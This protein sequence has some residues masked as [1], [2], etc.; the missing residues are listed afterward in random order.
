MRKN[1]NLVKSVVLIRL[2]K[3]S[4][5]IYIIYITEVLCKVTKIQCN[6]I[7]LFQ[8]YYAVIWHSMSCTVNGHCSVCIKE[9]WLDLGRFSILYMVLLLRGP[10]HS[11]FLRSGRTSIACTKPLESRSTAVPVSTSIDRTYN[12]NT[13]ANQFKSFRLYMKIILANDVYIVVIKSY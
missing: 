13:Y 5:C 2:C 8:F 3:I 6:L 4:I 7:V 1:V 11:I 10:L 12:T 9:S